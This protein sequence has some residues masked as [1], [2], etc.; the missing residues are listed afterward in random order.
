VK[1]R[2]LTAATPMRGEA[3]PVQPNEEKSLGGLWSARDD[4]LFPH[5][6]HES[7]S[8]VEEHIEGTTA[9]VNR[10]QPTLVESP[11]SFFLISLNSHI[12]RPREPSWRG[13]LSTRLDDVQRVANED[14]ERAGTG[15]GQETQG[16]RV[17]F[18]WRGDGCGRGGEGSRGDWHGWEKGEMDGRRRSPKGGKA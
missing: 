9:L 7:L 4:P 3:M 5:G 13:S 10:A 15:A 11:Q 12:H 14:L 6:A 18:G 2:E 1:R 17:G 8:A 16:E